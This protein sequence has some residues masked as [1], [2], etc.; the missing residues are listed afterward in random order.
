[1]F[2]FTREIES[3]VDITIPVQKVY[4]VLCSRSNSHRAYMQMLARC[5]NVSDRQIDIANGSYLKINGNHS[6]WTY[7]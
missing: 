2:I 4:G 3:G 5:R 7:K 6:F 1:M